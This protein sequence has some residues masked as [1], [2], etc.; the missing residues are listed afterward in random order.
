MGKYS[1]LR[2]EREESKRER[3][4]GY[5]GWFVYEHK[6]DYKKTPTNPSSSG[7]QESV[8]L[9]LGVSVNRHRPLSHPPMFT[10]PPRRGSIRGP[11]D[12]LEG[13]PCSVGGLS[14]LRRS[15]L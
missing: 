7:H 6:R 3:E 5:E 9:N 8:L 10:P 14:F 15:I 13:V 4:E 1:E 11:Y 2:K 12:E